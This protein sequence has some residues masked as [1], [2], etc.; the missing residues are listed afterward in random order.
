MPLGG[1][2]LSAKWTINQY[3]ITFDSAG[4]STVAPITQ[5]YGP[6]VTAPADPTRAGYTFAG[7]SPAVPAT[8]PLGG[9]ALTA[10]WTANDYTITFN[11]NGG[12]DPA[13]ASKVVT[14]DSAYGTMATASRTGYT[15]VG[16]FTA[17]SGGTEVTAATIVSTASNHT[18]YA[19]WMVNTYT[20]TFDSQG[21]APTPAS[22]T[23][24]FGGLIT[25][26]TDPTKTG[27]T[28]NGWF[29]A[30]TGGTQWNFA[31]NTMGAGDMTLY[32]RWT[33]NEYT[34]TVN[35]AHGA[36][37]KSPDKTTYIY[38]EEVTLSVTPDAGWTFAILDRWCNRSD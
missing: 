6:P 1:A 12:S 36:V 33:A 24:A 22:Q 15:F 23:V 2:A 30:A 13:P 5:D 38:G 7:W 20:V 37:T 32:A 8:M 28:F 21:G 27:H 29:D 14:F 4:G 16:W 10:Q 25:A 31:T 35:S 18:L 34:L 19:Q 11:A 26:P 9:A 3:T 17:A